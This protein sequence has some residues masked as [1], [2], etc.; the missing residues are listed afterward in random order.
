M[1]ENFRTDSAYDATERTPY[2]SFY[3]EPMRNADIGMEQATSRSGIDDRL[4]SLCWSV[5]NNERHREDRH[6]CFFFIRKCWLGSC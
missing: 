4:K 2:A 3:F 5:A 6:R 1:I